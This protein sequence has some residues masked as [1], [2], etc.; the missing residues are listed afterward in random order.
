MRIIVLLLSTLLMTITISAKDKKVDTN[1]YGLEYDKLKLKYP[2]IVKMPVIKAGAKLYYIDDETTNFFK[3]VIDYPFGSMNDRKEFPGETYFT[4][5]TL[6]NGGSENYPV[7]VLDSLKDVLSISLGFSV[8]TERSSVTMSCINNQKEVALD[9]LEDIISSPRF[10]SATLA[11]NK[12]SVRES[13]L[14]EI[15]EPSSF[16]SKKFREHMYGKNQYGS[17]I[18]GDTASLKKINPDV[19]RQQYR[20]IKFIGD[21]KVG[22]VGDVSLISAPLTAWQILGNTNKKDSYDADRHIVSLNVK[23]ESDADVIFYNKADLNQ[24]VIRWGNRGINYKNKDYYKINMATSVLGGGSFTSRLMNE[25]RVKRGL[26]YSVGYYGVQNIYNKGYFVGA[27]QTQ[28]AKTAEALNVIMSTTDEYIKN[29]VTQEE[30]DQF[31]K[32]FV[33]NMPF[34]YN[35]Y[36]GFLNIFMSYENQGRETDNIKKL[37]DIYSAMTVEEV[38]DVIK[39]YIYSSDKMD[40]VMV[41]NYEAVKESLTKILKEKNLKIK[42]IDI[43]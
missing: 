28:T 6:V 8:T 22:I 37:A 34:L 5:K 16:A 15:E 20:N 1:V 12:T 2:K 31:K 23:K 40:Y 33:N 24:T 39:K 19:L 10:D 43:K 18:Y 29:G 13:I 32:T 41:G 35:S 4:F 3:I 36:V 25:I 30:L 11:I 21:V 17:S 27:C 7:D 9:I 38:N 26:S 42:V 14:R